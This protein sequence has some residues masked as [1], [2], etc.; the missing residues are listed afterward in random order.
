VRE[1]VLDASVVVKWF[2]RD[3]ARHVEHARALRA[4]YVQGELFV[5]A[6]PLLRLELLNVAGRQWLLGEEALTTLAGAFEDIGFELLEP[7]LEGVARW[8]AR[9]LSAYDAAYVAVA[10]SASA[11]L[12]TDDDAI[13]AAAPE[14]ARPLAAEA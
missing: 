14:L 11:T 10:E 12:V 1:V 2:R 5:W 3:G 8:V 7:P 6:P 4:S 13:V 9:G